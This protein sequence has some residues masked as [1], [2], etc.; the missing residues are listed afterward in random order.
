MLLIVFALLLV[1]PPYIS[2]EPDKTGAD[3]AGDRLKDFWVVR[4][5]LN[6]LGYATVV[7]P[8]FLIIRHVRNTNY[9]D[10]ASECNCELKFDHFRCY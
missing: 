4:L 7:L 10:T 5:L 2:G 6:L 3:G 8:G 1:T 9:L